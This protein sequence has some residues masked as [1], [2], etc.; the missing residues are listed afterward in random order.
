MSAL[1]I[2]FYTTVVITLFSV[3][4]AAQV[5]EQE[6]LQAEEQSSII[7]LAPNLPAVVCPS[8]GTPQTEPQKDESNDYLPRLGGAGGDESKS[9]S[10]LKILRQAALLYA[11][12]RSVGKSSILDSD[13][14]NTTAD[15]FN[16]FGSKQMTG[17]F[18]LAYLV[19]NGETKR[20]SGTV[21]EATMEAMLITEGL[22]YLTGRKRPRESGSDPDQWFGPGTG[23]ASFPSGHTSNAFAIATVLSEKHPKQKWLY[24]LLAAGV[25]YARV[26]K[27]AH[28][29]SDV[30]I[31]AGI[32]IYAGKKAV[33]GKSLTRKV[34]KLGGSYED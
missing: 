19:S 2:L 33:K 34:I 11:L 22:K 20:T 25:A 18:G 26:Q 24:Y 12:D 27:D 16:G 5:D 30:F 7:Y 3:M 10:A 8:A 32:G 14:A 4:A 1:C 29:P 31:G 17:L 9:D 23:Y 28:F 6:S 21:L 15:L 13:G